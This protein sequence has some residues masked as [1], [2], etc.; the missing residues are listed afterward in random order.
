MLLK[1][2][3]QALI[4]AVVLGLA[5]FLPAG[6]LAWAQGWAFL[7]L[8]VGC[9]QS[10]IRRQGSLSPGTGCV[11]TLIRNPAVIERRRSGRTLLI[12]ML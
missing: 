9:G 2:T 7:I 3:V 5:L 1:M 4:S 8:F 6:T 10:R 11:V 12:L